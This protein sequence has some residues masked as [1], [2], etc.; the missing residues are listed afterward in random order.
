MV[1][2]FRFFLLLFLSASLFSCKKESD[3]IV[4]ESDRLVV[5]QLSDKTFVHISYLNT[6]DFGKVKCNG[7]IFINKNEA[8]ILDTPTNDDASKELIDWIESDLNAKIVA[9]IPTHFHDDCV[10]GI[11][12]FEKKKIPSFATTKTIE[13]A[14]ASDI[15]IGSEAFDKQL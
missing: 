6:N 4:F 2:F 11:D 8:V 12:A 15:Y 9:L 5:K 1:G 13:L 7:A 3:N 14:K 10:G